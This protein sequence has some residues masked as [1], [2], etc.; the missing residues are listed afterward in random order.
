MDI[1]KQDQLKTW[2]WVAIIFICLFC[3]QTCSK[4]SGNQNAAFIERNH[5]EIIDSLT[6]DN[7]ELQDSVLILI[8][9]LQTFKKS[10]QALCEENDYLRNVLKQ[11]QLKPVIIYKELNKPIK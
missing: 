9:D 4:C 1:F 5:I 3:F 6:K 8:G 11:S 10:N 7:K 2:K